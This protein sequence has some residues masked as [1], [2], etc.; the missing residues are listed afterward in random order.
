MTSTFTI[1]ITCGVLLASVVSAAPAP[2]DRCSASKVKATAKN[3]LKTHLCHAKASKKGLPVDVDCLFK[4][5]DRMLASFNKAEGKGGCLTIADFVAV[6]AIADQLVSDNVSALPDAGGS[7][8]QAC[9]SSKR[10]AAGKKASG[11]L[12]CRAKAAKRAEPV[13]GNCLAKADGK[14]AASFSKAESK[15]GCATAGDSGSICSAVD[16]ASTKV[17]A[18]LVSFCGD[19]ISGPNEECDGSEDAACPG[20]CDDACTC[21]TV[22]G[23]NLTEGSEDCDG[24]DDAACPGECLGSC[25]C[26][27]DCGDGSVGPGEECDD[28]GNVSGDGCRDDCELE[29]TSALCAGVPSTP[30]T[31]LSIELVGV[32]SSPVHVTAAPLDPS[33]LFVVEQGGTIRVIK[34]GVVLPTPFLDIDAQVQSGGERGLLSLAFHPDYENNGRFFVNYTREPDGDTVVARFTVSGNPDVADAGSEAILFTIEQPFSNHNGGQIA[35]GPDD[36]LYV[37]MGDGGGGGDPVEAGQDDSQLLAKMLRVDVD[38]DVAPYH[39]VPGDNPN[40][41]AG[42][43]LGL[44]WAKGLRNPWRFAFDRLTGEMFIGDV[45][46]NQVE[47]ISYQSGSSTGGENYGWNDMEGSACFDPAVGCLTAGRELPIEEFT[48][49]EGCS[50]TGGHVYRG[51]ALPDMDG[52]YFYSDF[53]A[54][55]IRT[56]EVL[57]GVAINQAD[58]TAEVGTSG[59][60]STFGEDARGELYIVNHGGQVYRMIPGP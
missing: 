36:R 44:I 21:A 53:C 30:G 14:L 57:A 49:S 56:F 26:M 59:S 51:C 8:A 35:F 42:L 5:A 45:G 25:V 17:T 52:T 39:A 27:G 38:V 16:V 4:A 28:G 23:N 54:G 32:F 6:E 60:V 9:A 43:P 7:D 12:K 11:R 29:D 46:Q 1:L 37:G 10:K 58:R 19:D 55:F 31:S 33:R 40:A 24:T 50:V 15:G 41:G 2:A 3:A 13:E 34:D 20:A 22:C 47:E 18:A 48:H